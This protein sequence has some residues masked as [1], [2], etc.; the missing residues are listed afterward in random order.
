MTTERQMTWDEVVAEMVRYRESAKKPDDLLRQAIE[1]LRGING[2]IGNVDNSVGNG[3]NSARVR[4][5]LLNDFREISA[6]VLT[7]YDKR[8]E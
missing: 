5:G 4:G 3:E 6:A 1:A 8:G 2:M 7:A